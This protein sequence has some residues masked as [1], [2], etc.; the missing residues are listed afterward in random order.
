MSITSSDTQVF[1]GGAFLTNDFP[2]A[3]LLT[4][5]NLSEE[6]RMISQTA[7]RF[8]VERVMANAEKIEKK[9]HEM[10][11]TVLRESAELGL[12][13]AEIPEEYGGTGLDLLSTMLITEQIARLASFSVSFGGHS[14]IGT[15]PVRYFG[16]EEQKQKWLPKLAACEV[17]SCYAL[18]ENHSGSDALAAR[19]KAVLSEDGKHYILNGSKMWITNGGIADLSMVFAKVDGQHFT[20]FVVETNTPGFSAAAEERKMGLH[21]SSTTALTLENVKVP[22]ENLVGEIGKGHKIALNVLNL[23]RFKLGAW[24][25]AAAKYALNDAIS[26]SKDRHQFG[27]AICE[28]GAIRYKL[29]QMAVR[30]WVGDAM[31]YRTAGMIEHSL[32]ATDSKDPIAALKAIEEYVAECSILKVACSE[33]LDYVV[34]EAVQIHG[35]YGYSAEYAVE[36]HYRDSRI[37]RIFEGTNE[38]NRLTITGSILKKAMSGKLNLAGGVTEVESNVLQAEKKLVGNAKKAALLAAGTAIQTI[39]ADNPEEKHQETL[40][41]IADLAIEV[42]AMDSAWLRAAKQAGEKGED[43]IELQKDILNVFLVDS[44]TRLWTNARQLLANLLPA[45]E[46]L[47]KTIGKIDFLV[48]APPANTQLPLQRI[49]A[50]LLEAGKYSA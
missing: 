41:R 25:A 17:I 5:D 36:R 18:T 2:V 44:T 9:D 47:Q 30:C 8:M 31:N 26:Y 28:F 34:D 20:C 1:P 37:N 10:L 11:K 13:G 15:A 49:A 14:G 6:H 7:E 48:G 42:F 33:Y 46:A 23:G 45:G 4:P 16:N 40:M 35:G 38:I 39:A 32:G 24:C 29:A 43:K 12:L 19:T 27:K 22:V 3:D 50:K 21:G